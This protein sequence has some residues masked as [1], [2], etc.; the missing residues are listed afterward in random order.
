MSKAGWIILL[1]LLASNAAWIATNPSAQRP[2]DAPEPSQ[3]PEL[4]AQLARLET[5]IA[6][7]NATPARTER[8]RR[9]ASFQEGRATAWQ[10]AKPW[11]DD[12]LQIADSR[13]HASALRE[14]EEALSGADPVASEGAT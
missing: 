1:A 2:V 11:I 3:V 8:K 7:A 12:L 10:R 5:E 6:A 14:M 9:E 13:K 4:K